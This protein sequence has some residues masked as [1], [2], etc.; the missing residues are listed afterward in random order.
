[1]S[2]KFMGKLLIIWLQKF[3]VH[4][5]VK[6]KNHLITKMEEDFYQNAVEWKKT[7]SNTLAFRLANLLGAG[8]LKKENQST[9]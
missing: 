1:M 6:N 8:M 9:I 7:F 4:Y 3:A 5:T 2:Q